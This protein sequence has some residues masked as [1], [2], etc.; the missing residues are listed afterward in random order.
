MSTILGP[1]LMGTTHS[2]C[3]CTARRPSCSPTRK[4]TARAHSRGADGYTYGLSGTPTARTLETQL[5][6]LNAA[7]RA[8]VVSSG[9]A[10]VS[11]LML[12]V[13]R[14]GDEI[15]ID[16]RAFAAYLRKHGLEGQKIR[17]ISCETGKHPKG[18]AQHLAN[19]LGVEVLAPSDVAWIHSDGRVTIGHRNRNLGQ[20]VPYQPKASELRSTP[21]APLKGELSALSAR[22]RPRSR[23]SD[24]RQPR[25]PRPAARASSATEQ[26]L[27]RLLG[28]PVVF[29]P[30]LSNGVE[31]QVHRVDRRLGF[32][33]EVQRV[34]IGKDA[35]LAD[36]LTH[37]T[38][39]KSVERYNGVVGLLRQ[40]AERFARWC[41]KRPAAK[42][43]HGSRAW[44]TQ[45]ELTK[46]DTL[47][48]GRHA[49]LGQGKVD[50]HTLAEEITFLSGRR[51]YHEEVLQS[52]EDDGGPG[53]GFDGDFSLA[54]PDTGR[55]T[56]EA[57]AAGYPLPGA[58]Q[59]VDPSWYYYRHKRHDPGEFELALKPTSPHD[60]PSLQA[61]TLSGRFIGFDKPGRAHGAE[62]PYDMAP[63]QVVAHLRKTVGFKSYA[64]M[65]ERSG[66]ASRDLI[67]GIVR[68][69][70]S[71]RMT[72][73]EPVTTDEVRQAVKSYFRPRLMERLLDPKRSDAESWQQLREMIDEL[74][75]ADRGNL[76]EDWYRGRHLPGAEARVGVGVE[77]TTGESAGQIES[78]VIDAVDGGTAVEIKDISGKLDE[79]QLRAYLD[80]LAA[81]LQTGVS[82]KVP[83]KIK[84]VKYVFTKPEGAIA[85]LKLFADKL[86]IKDNVG[87]LSAEVF[88]W[89]GNRHT[90]TTAAQALQ[91]LRQ[92]TTTRGQS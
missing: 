45:Q 14:Q 50:D 2:V 55:V 26:E 37:A 79:E 65:L 60:A 23:T 81:K 59:G 82:G 47:L 51:A 44:K 88:D 8:I 42:V 80:M 16:Q 22:G 70:R 75:S 73:G 21:Y 32:A 41:G 29:D 69:V 92:L 49:D 20:W 62:I 71:E 52:L 1:T 11:A 90:V 58:D 31:V 24:A 4:A 40:L 78:R 83:P 56:A 10:A 66:L 19:K 77:R 48:T 53:G 74:P 9:Q 91:L 87:R 54:A 64:E 86:A 67:D 89:Q 12:T 15:S 33:L 30:H 63:D 17:L 13:L 43:P 36:V 6:L 39:I 3:R 25:P 46:L 5:A 38:T 61:R 27:A 34:R 28:A 84:K 35:L 57:G 7:E 68:H 72:T 85:N 18:I 76:A